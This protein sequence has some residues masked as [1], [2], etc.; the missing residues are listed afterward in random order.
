MLKIQSE[1]EETDAG[2]LQAKYTTRL[3]IVYGKTSWLYKYSTVETRL[4]GEKIEGQEKRASNADEISFALRLRAM[5]FSKLLPHIV[6]R[7]DGAI[8]FLFQIIYM[9]GTHVY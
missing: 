2:N 9:N 1:R 5:F 4:E 7:A 8:Y 6:T 3:Y